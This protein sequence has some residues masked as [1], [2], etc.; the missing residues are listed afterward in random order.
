M[1]VEINITLSDSDFNK[2]RLLKRSDKADG[3]T[4]NEYAEELLTTEIFSKYWDYRKKNLLI[5]REDD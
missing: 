3:K 4:Y 2:L 1:S 5:Q